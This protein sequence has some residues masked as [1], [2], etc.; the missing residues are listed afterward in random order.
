YSPGLGDNNILPDGGL[1]FDLFPFSWPTNP[2]WLYALTQGLHVVSGV[3][4]IPLL[5]AKLWSVMPK[6]FEWPPLRSVAHLFERLSLALLVG[7]ALFVFFTGVLNIQLYYPWSFSFV[8]SHYYAA[9]VFLAALALHVGLKVPTIRKAFR[10]RGVT[11]PLKADLSQTI[12]EPYQEGTTTPLEPAAAT[13]SRRA[14]IASVGAASIGIGA[15]MAGQVIGGPL[16]SIALLAPHGTDPGDGPNGFQINRTAE[17]AGVGPGETGRGW[18]LNLEGGR[19]VGLS[20]EQLLAMP[21][22]T[23]DLPIACVEGWSTTQTWT[24]VR[25][26]DLADAAGATGASQVLVESLQEAGSFNKATLSS[27]QIDDE[28]SLLALR[29][30]GVDLSPDHGFPARVIVPALPGVH[31]TKWVRS[32]KFEAA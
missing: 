8:P 14:L 20:R 29:V 27:A 23:Y 22:H 5:F 7:G 12:A 31:C 10:E 2:A 11:R 4:A 19:T 18:R 25:L 15:M 21:Q 28:K 30:N 3:I 1:G 17:A 26:R 16:R 13:L 24:G 6:L 32:M 9:I